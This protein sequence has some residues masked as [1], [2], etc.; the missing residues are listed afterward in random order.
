V[1]KVLLMEG[2]VNMDMHVTMVDAM[3]IAQYK[4]GLRELNE[5]QLKCA[6][7]TDEGVVSLIDAMHIAQWKAGVPFKPLWESPADDDMLKPVDP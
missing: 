1:T 4:A 6:D 5:S 3:Y 2:D 7:T